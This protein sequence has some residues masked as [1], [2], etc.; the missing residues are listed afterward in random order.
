MLNQGNQNNTI[1]HD[2]YVQP[3]LTRV[4]ETQR[5]GACRRPIIV[6]ELKSKDG[7]NYDCIDLVVPYADI[8]LKWTILFDSEFPEL[9]PDFIFN[10]DF[11]L[12]PDAN[13]LIENVPSLNTWNYCDSNSLLLVLKELLTY[14]KK[15]Q[16]ELIKNRCQ[17]RLSFEY[18]ELIKIVKEENVEVIIMNNGLKSSEV[19]FFI[20]LTI[21]FSRI[22]QKH[23]HHL[24]SDAVLLLVTFSGSDYSNVVP[25][26]QLTK[27]IENI[28]GSQETLSIPP[29]PSQDGLLIEYVPLIENFLKG[30]V[31]AL[32]SNCKRKR[33]F[34]SSLL[35][36]L[37]GSIIEYDALEFNQAT[38]LVEKKDF[39]F[40]IH[41]RIPSRF[42]REKPEVVMESAYHM[43]RSGKMI[44]HTISK[45]PHNYQAESISMVQ[46]ILKHIEEK[47]VEPFQQMC[48]QKNRF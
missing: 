43:D 9:G 12:N 26:L 37:R 23:K 4:L 10:D 1:L 17:R 38:F 14:Y 47:E 44:T 21:D 29:Y 18:E 3:L 46:T 28:L 13:S 42:P 8:N 15:K 25:A 39:H 27:T 20:R 33:D 22:P 2:T 48:T 35:I 6:H 31:E 7:F 24:Q 5:F 30:K 36:I 19:K 34:I 40:F 45:Y 16:I 41:F 11:L 32:I